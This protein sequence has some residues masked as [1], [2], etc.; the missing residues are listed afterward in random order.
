MI[1]SFSSTQ[2]STPFM[3]KNKQIT[4]NENGMS[5][6]RDLKLKNTSNTMNNLSSSTNSTTKT[7]QNKLKSP[8]VNR[9]PDLL[10]T[11][12]FCLSSSQLKNEKFVSTNINNPNQRTS[13][14]IKLALNSLNKQD[15]HG[16]ADYSKLNL[17]NV[18]K[19]NETQAL[20][21]ATNKSLKNSGILAKTN[22]SLTEKEK[23]NPN[24]SSSR[25]TSKTTETKRADCSDEYVNG[26]NKRQSV[27]SIIFES[28]S[29][30]SDVDSSSMQSERATMKLKQ[31]TANQNDL[32]STT[33]KTISYGYFSKPKST[34]D[35]LSL[36]GTTSS[37]SSANSSYTSHPHQN[38]HLSIPQPFKKS[39]FVQNKL[40]TKNDNNLLIDQIASFID[41][42]KDFID[43]RLVDTN[44]QLELANQHIVKLYK[45]IGCLTDELMHL[46]IQNENF[47]RELICLNAN[48]RS[49]NH[50]IS[51][52]KSKQSST[53]TELNKM[54]PLSANVVSSAINRFSNEKH[55]LVSTSSSPDT[56]Q[57]TKICDRVE[58]MNQCPSAQM[59]EVKISFKNKQ[60]RRENA[61][62][63]SSS[64]INLYD[65][66]LGHDE[67]NKGE[68]EI[69]RFDRIKAQ[70][71]SATKFK[72]I[73]M[74]INSNPYVNSSDLDS[75]K[76][77]NSNNDDVLTS[78][79]KLTNNEDRQLDEF[80][81]DENGKFS[82][83]SPSLTPPVTASNVHTS[84][85]SNTKGTMNR[86]SKSSNTPYFDLLNELENQYLWDYT[87]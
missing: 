51:R 40:E 64:S 49:S 26:G 71:E 60:N 17:N 79:E 31:Q 13:I 67:E 7:L 73:N 62:K 35:L 59:Q 39:Q 61:I 33:S 41:E 16:K 15:Q 63:N 14:G 21:N 68:K 65:N 27:E 8:I 75:S 3:A 50:R 53:T 1:Q 47:K 20:T 19:T 2:S 10:N 9:K 29:K 22:Y 85:K 76:N 5:L 56:R 30:T 45:N 43:D 77:V 83:P 36:S 78:F 70:F 46:K 80:N 32:S 81:G 57:P 42:L 37:F 84:T 23:P 25:V 18:F 28:P 11:F 82:S 58:R 54:Y 69:R 52:R 48:E 72:P 34:E 38:Q 12:G 4:A 44:S 66:I 6:I 87:D 74:K 86:L 24:T 55:I